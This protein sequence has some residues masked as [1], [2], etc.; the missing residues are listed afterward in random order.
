MSTALPVAEQNNSQQSLFDESVYYFCK[1]SALATS[2]EGRTCGSDPLQ[3]CADLSL[4]NLTFYRFLFFFFSKLSGGRM[5]SSSLIHEILTSGGFFFFFLLN[6]CIYIA[7]G[8]AYGR[9]EQT[10]A[11]TRALADTHEQQRGNR[12]TVKHLHPS[13]FP[14]QQVKS[15]SFYNFV[16][17]S[18]KKKKKC[19]H[20]LKTYSGA[21]EV[22]WWIF[23]GG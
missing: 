16:L 20:L 12:W 13:L 2:W 4:S 1:T 9:H 6:T 23:G 19:S 17:Y 14:W 5:Y 18:P 15:Y 8:E 3:K 21:E 10:R 11:Q 7:H 22:M